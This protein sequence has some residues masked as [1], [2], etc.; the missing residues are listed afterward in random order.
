MSNHNLI[1]E[2]SNGKLTSLTPISSGGGHKLNSEAAAAYEKMVKAAKEDGVEWGITDSYRTYEVQNK[3]F[4]WDYF[5]KTKK[6]RKKGTSGTPVAYPGTS[7]HGWGAAVDL[8]VKYGDKA[9]TWLTKHASEFGFSNP[10]KNPR[11]EPW[12]WEHVASAKKLGAGS[13]VETLPPSNET[14][15][16]IN[17][18]LNQHFENLKNGDDDG[19]GD[20][21]KKSGYTG[22]TG[23]LLKLIGFNENHNISN[24]NVLVEE[25]TRIKE[26]LK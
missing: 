17:D 3:I 13:N 24:K 14:D 7:N 5:K 25:I 20:S 4:D 26:L 1:T 23:A 10:F 15:D 12:H 18:K 8:V 21:N 6:R 19:G 9:H 16:D 11:T 2:A 22:L